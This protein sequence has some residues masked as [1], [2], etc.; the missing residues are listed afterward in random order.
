MFEFTEEAK[1]EILKPLKNGGLI[2]GVIRMRLS[3]LWKLVVVR[4]AP[5][6]AKDE[7]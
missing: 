1:E 5:L 7:V 4:D 3:R 6:R 2:V